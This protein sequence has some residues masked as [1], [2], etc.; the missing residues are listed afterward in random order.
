MLFRKPEEEREVQIGELEGFFREMFER[1]SEKAVKRAEQVEPH[2]THGLHMFEKAAEALAEYNG[3]PDE[4]FIGRASISSAKEQKS[5]YT[6]ALQKA[7][8]SLAAELKDAHA[9]TRYETMLRKKD[10]YTEFVSKV[11]SLNSSFKLAVLGYSE[12]MGDFKKSFS[13]IEKNLKA[14]ESELGFGSEAFRQYESAI[15]HVQALLGGM[16]NIRLASMQNDYTQKDA[17]TASSSDIERDRSALEGKIREISAKISDCEKRSKSIS[18]EM[19]LLL[20]PIERVSRKYDHSIPSKEGIGQYI[21]DPVS[22]LASELSYSNFVSL[23]NDM[24]KKIEQGSIEIKN[25]EDVLSQ[26]SLILNTNLSDMAYQAMKLE[27]EKAELSEQLKSYD[28][29]LHKVHA[30]KS[31]TDSLI[32]ER[33]TAAKRLSYTKAEAEQRKLTIERLAYDLYKVRLKIV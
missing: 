17:A 26:I 16:E 21:A 23:L 27:S 2:I 1:E 32:R 30:Q 11:L 3:E 14:L 4:E 31:S 22:K 8:A 7:L 10:I 24:R 5:H 12:R 33:E 20:L 9:G 15:G 19:E 28:I 18:A 13:V 25:K 6:D 29:E